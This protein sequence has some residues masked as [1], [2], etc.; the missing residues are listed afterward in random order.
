M[1][2]GLDKTCKLSSV[3]NRYV[4]F[5]NEQHA[6]SKVEVSDLEFVHTHVLSG[7]DTPEAAALMKNDRIAV[8][9]EHSNDRREEE[10][11]N[12]IQR[13]SDKDYFQQLRQLLPPGR[14]SACA[15][16]MFADTVLD[17]RGFLNGKRERQTTTITCHYAIIHKRCPWLAG[18]IMSARQERDRRSSVS[19][20]DETKQ[21]EDD[22]MDFEL[23]QHI[24]VHK[25]EELES[26][27]AQIENDEDEHVGGNIDGLAQGRASRNSDSTMDMEDDDASFNC[28]P[29]RQSQAANLAMTV[30]VNHPPAAMKLLLEYCYSNRVVSLGCEAFVQSCKTK[31][32]YKRLQGPVPPFSFRPTRWPASGEPI[33]SFAVAL[34]GIQLAEEAD[35]PRLSLM[36]EIAAS[37]L[38]DY[39]SAVEALFSCGY[40]Q[41]L[42]GNPLPRLRKAAMEIVFR[43]QHSNGNNAAA[44]LGNALAEK[45]PLLVPTLITGTME[46]VEAAEKK[47]KQ[48]SDQS[49]TGEKRD[50]QTMAYSYFDRYDLA[51]AKERDRERRKR[52]V[53][54]EDDGMSVIF[55]D[56][57][58]WG[59]SDDPQAHVTALSLKRMS[60]RL[61]RTL[62]NR[63]I[64]N[65]PRHDCS[66][67]NAAQPHQPGSR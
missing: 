16:E 54:L 66:K 62:G 10:I 58:S 12:R 14:A 35:M 32:Q 46:A 61:G 20:P 8:R 27:A 39:S 49:V 60:H 21:S 9:R 5:C 41:K 57:E 26:N 7:H 38:V 47:K 48:H 50:W 52:R 65:L 67:S 63:I 2:I 17:C 15:E 55:E 37:Q 42:T 51:D 24:K 44:L 22:D 29:T 56:D 53:F 1:Q 34:A 3:F 59:A 23:I 64:A 28:V 6:D 33:I 11:W 30:V 45:G 43:V 4:E 40:Q 25:P 13:D 36:C 19:F 31:P 18:I